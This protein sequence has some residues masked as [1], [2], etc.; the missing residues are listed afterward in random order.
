[1]HQR[2]LSWLLIGAVFAVV[3]L[4]AQAPAGGGKGK[5]D[6]P[7][8]IIV[9]KIGS[10]KPTKTVNNVT[11][12]LA[13]DMV[14]EQSATVRTHAEGSVV[15]VFSN[16]ATT[17]L[18]NDT[19]LVIDEFLQDPFNATVKVSDLDKEPSPSRT[20]LSL[21]R[22]EIIGDVKQLRHDQDSSFTVQ[23]PVGAAGI[24]GT[25]FRIVFRPQANGQA[26]FT[27]TTQT[28]RVDYAPPGS[29]G[30]T[31]G[32]TNVQAQGTA[33]VQVP[34]GQEIEI[35]VNVTTNA[36]GQ[37]VSVTPITPAPTAAT[38]ARV[39]NM[40][41]VA[42]VATEIAVA[43]QNAVFT[44]Q[45]PT[46]TTPGG[47][48]TTGSVTGNPPAPQ[49]EQ[50]QS[51]Q[52]QQQQ[53]S[54]QQGGQQQQQQSGTQSQPQ[55]TGQTQQQTGQ[56]SQ[57]PSGQS[58]SQTSQ[59]TQSQTFTTVTQTRTQSATVTT[60]VTKSIPTGQLGSNTSPP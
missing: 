47:G 33:A 24:R 14:V 35:Q 38:A 39:E 21:N 50:Q 54:S 1:M 41:Q 59:Q 53:Q 45:P 60:T 40:A 15:L 8:R 10:G 17:K 7:G 58:Q 13:V 20:K 37:I 4:R 52:Q 18:G 31:P 6:Q 51:G 57:Q 34:Q 5:F 26:F 25:I 44:S 30:T 11:T 2:I 48:T 55:Q 22:G 19:E 43:V 32:V 28:G 36:Q 56:T 9:A 16:G 29:G 12:E 23:T 49:Q 3:S 27:L 42:A 46:G